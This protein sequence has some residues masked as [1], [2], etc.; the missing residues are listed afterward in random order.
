VSNLEQSPIETPCGG[1]LA[2]EEP[3]AAKLAGRDVPLGRYTTVQR[4]LPH[5]DRRTVGA[6]CFLD[7]FGPDALGDGPG[8]R[9]PPHPHTGLQTVSWLFA[10]EILHRDSLGSLQ[11]IRPGQLNLMT[12][13]HGIAHSEESPSDHQQARPGHR[14]LHGLQLWVALPE[15]ALH[16]PAAFEHHASLPVISLEGL[17]L[18]VVMGEH[19]GVR[20]P[21]RAYTPIVGLEITV[22]ESRSEPVRLVPD[23]EYA[24]V[25]AAGTAEVDGVP[26]DPGTLL[27]LG[28]GRSSLTVGGPVGTRLFLIGGEPFEEELVMWWNFVGRSHEDIVEARSAWEAATDRFG[29]VH[30]YDGDRLGAPA[31]PNARLKSRDR[32]GRPA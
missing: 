32:N 5:R 29:V 19:A 28:R 15:D 31:L 16:G 11:L 3:V 25:S 4:V 22:R 26:L 2:V 23:F 8:M 18:T 30:G 12:S 9:V 24:A 1:A 13:G 20:S 21:A 17:N 14:I 6:W 7:Q 27:Y 10:G